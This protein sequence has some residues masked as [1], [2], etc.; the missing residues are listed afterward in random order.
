MTRLY[1]S[2]KPIWDLAR[3]YYYRWARHDLTIKN[4]M[5]PDLPEIIHA[6]NAL[7]A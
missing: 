5:H 4:P 6:I 1:R 7:E 2:I 3:L